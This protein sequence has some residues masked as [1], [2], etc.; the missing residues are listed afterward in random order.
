MSTACRPTTPTFA[1]LLKAPHPLHATGRNMV[2]PVPL[3]NVNYEGQNLQAVPAALLAGQ[4]ATDDLHDGQLSAVAQRPP[5]VARL[6]LAYNA[7][8]TI[9]AELFLAIATHLRVLRLDNNSL[10]SLPDSI[11]AL[12]HLETLNLAHNRLF[13]LPRTL[14]RLRA[15]RHLY[16][17]HNVLT[18]LPV[19]MRHLEQ[20]V[21]L[22]VDGNPLSFPPPYLWRPAS[23][24]VTP[25]TSGI[26]SPATRSRSGTASSTVPRSESMGRD[27]RKSAVPAS[28]GDLDRM[29]VVNVRNYLRIAA[30][31]HA[32][33]DDDLGL[34]E[35]A[36]PPRPVAPTCGATSPTTALRPI[37]A[38]PALI[39]SPTLHPRPAAPMRLGTTTS[40]SALAVSTDDPDDPTRAPAELRAFLSALSAAHAE[41]PPLAAGARRL[42][43]ATASLA[44]AALALANQVGN[45][46]LRHLVGVVAGAARAYLRGLGPSAS[47]RARSAASTPAFHALVKAWLAVVAATRKVL[48]VA[49]VRDPREIKVLAAVLFQC[50][51][52]WKVCAE[53]VAPLG[54]GEVPVAVAG[55]DGRGREGASM[56]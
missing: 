42:L 36:P 23:P 45:V 14:G 9:P 33:D 54:R 11:G 4:P 41:T 24:V 10:G 44:S 43:D 17:N 37:A 26:V 19:A 20:L 48:L 27:V 49:A 29:I 30:A 39:D 55:E 28:R 50:V 16:L 8:T 6:S 12:V 35:L 3:L 5:A 34:A 15:L 51:A 52:E 21:T 7:L 53:L 13:Q 22:Q 47:H 40:L 56:S 31:C 38:T 2:A 32:G 1:G 46:E 18:E 25:S